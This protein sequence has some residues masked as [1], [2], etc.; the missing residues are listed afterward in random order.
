MP[1]QLIYDQ[2]ALYVFQLVNGYRAIPEK[3]VIQVIVVGWGS[4]VGVRGG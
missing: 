2:P 4:E 3:R 1:A